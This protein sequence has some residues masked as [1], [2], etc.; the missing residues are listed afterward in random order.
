MLKFIVIHLI[1]KY[2]L[3]VLGSYSKEILIGAEYEESCPVHNRN[4]VL[5]ILGSTNSRS[6]FIASLT[7]MNFEYFVNVSRFNTKPIMSNLFC[8]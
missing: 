4:I 6:N 8:I 1:E 2:T 5:E 3:V 7:Y